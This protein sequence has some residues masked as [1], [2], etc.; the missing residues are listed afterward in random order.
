MKNKRVVISNCNNSVF[1]KA[2]G[3]N[4]TSITNSPSPNLSRQGR[5]ISPSLDGR[6]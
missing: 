5:G 1:S 6:D 4:A 2:Y 3:K